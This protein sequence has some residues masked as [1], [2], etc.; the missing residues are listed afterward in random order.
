VI[1]Y[2]LAAGEAALVSMCHAD[3]VNAVAYAD[4]AGNVL[5]SGSDDTRIFVHDRC[6]ATGLVG[7]NP[8]VV[9]CRR[10]RDTAGLQLLS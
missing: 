1:V 7:M 9:M 8:R 4:P 2:D 3:D 6:A 5:V 10:A